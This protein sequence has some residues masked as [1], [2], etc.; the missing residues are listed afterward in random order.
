MIKLKL[1]IALIFL[2]IIFTA[3]SKDDDDNSYDIYTIEDLNLLHN[4]S[5]KTWELEL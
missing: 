1:Q 5:P 2:L 4:N 3:C